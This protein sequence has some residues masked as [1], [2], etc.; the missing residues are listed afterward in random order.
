MK[1]W[2][3]R[4]GFTLI[5]LM[6]VIAIITVL[7]GVAIPKMSDLIGTARESRTKGNLGILRSALTVYYSETEGRYPAFPFPFSQPAGYGMLLNDTLVPRYL[8][9]IPEAMPHSAKHRS[10]DAV[11][12][13]WNLAGN[14]D[15]EPLSG[16]G[17]TYDANPFDE[18]KP[19]GFKGTWGTIQVL[20]RHLDSKGRNW[21]TY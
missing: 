18:I 9:E 21:S 15:D 7:T 11:Y 12:L 6:I 19:D 10:S 3:S 17:W 20:C 8:S 14:Q 5:E 16:Y 1:T 13:V 4:S 2:E